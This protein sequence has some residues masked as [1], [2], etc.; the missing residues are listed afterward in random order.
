MHFR[1][2]GGRFTHSVFPWLLQTDGSYRK[3]IGRVAAILTHPNG[4]YTNLVH[5]QSARNSYETEW[6]SVYNGMLFSLEHNATELTIE[7]DNLGVV[8]H[9]V[10]FPTKRCPDYVAH[11]KHA[12]RVLA[13]ETKHTGIRWIPRKFNRADDLFHKF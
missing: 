2:I 11:Y 12:I 4:R 9:L 1:Y 7:N 10:E 6:C 5:M 3:H 13:N 8:Q